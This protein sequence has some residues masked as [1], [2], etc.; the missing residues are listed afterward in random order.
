MSRH[1][2]PHRSM[3][4]HPHA[5]AE[6]RAGRR[7]RGSRGYRQDGDGEGPR[8]RSRHPG[9]RLQLLGPDG[10]QGYGFHLQGSGADGR[11][12]MLRRVQPNSRGGALRV[13]HPVQDRAGRHSRQEEPVHVRGRGDFV[14]AV[15][16]GVHHH[17]PRLPR[18]RRA[19][20]VAQGALPPGV[21]V[22]PRPRHDLRE[23]A[24]G[25]GLP[26]VQAPR[27]QVCDPLQTLPGSALRGAA[28]RLEAPRDQDD[29]VRRRRFKARPAAPHGGQGPAPGFARLQ[30]R[31]AHLGRPRNLH[32][33][34][35][36][37]V[38]Q[39]ARRRSPTARR[40][41]RGSDYQIR[42]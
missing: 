23:H 11:V 36:R 38:P 15:D 28:L 17:E 34:A 19:A 40:V 42:D 33:L 7:P 20:R 24:H 21:H 29:A 25:R 37:L 27:A 4:D 16:H 18:A 22:R 1:H 31:K 41:L 10:L 6:A 5:G 12:G 13:L 26:D 9:V 32:G 2:A 14:E 30:P 35:Q 39:D 8:P 3:R